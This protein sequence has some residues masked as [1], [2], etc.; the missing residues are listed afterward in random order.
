M[1]TPLAV[2]GSRCNQVGAEERL[3]SLDSEASHEESMATTLPF[4]HLL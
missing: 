2:R 4:S 1:K 3:L